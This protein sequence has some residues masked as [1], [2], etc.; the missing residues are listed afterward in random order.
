MENNNTNESCLNE[1]KDILPLGLS[2]DKHDK[3]S[4]KFAISD[5]DANHSNENGTFESV[6]EV[7]VYNLD[8]TSNVSEIAHIK[9]PA[10]YSEKT[11]TN[12]SSEQEKQSLHTDFTIIEGNRFGASV[13]ISSNAEHIV[14]ANY[15]A[16]HRY[17]G[18]YDYKRSMQN[19]IYVF[20]YN[21]S[22]QKYEHKNLLSKTDESNNLIWNY[23]TENGISSPVSSDV[24][25]SSELEVFNKI[26]PPKKLG[27][28]INQTGEVNFIN[29]LEMWEVG[30][31]PGGGYN[32]P[33]WMSHKY[34]SIIPFNCRICREFDLGFESNK[35]DMSLLHPN[36]QTTYGDDLI[37][38][39][40]IFVPGERW[41]G[42][43]AIKQTG[44]KR[45]PFIP[46][47]KISEDGT[48]ILYSTIGC[49]DT[50]N[51]GTGNLKSTD[52]IVPIVNLYGNDNK[53]FYA[54]PGNSF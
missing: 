49:K 41:D 39:N 13:D 36:L 32:I 34:A 17:K 6:G 29:N 52:D 42:D 3:Y 9:P 31:V 11:C 53:Y 28:E 20:E 37:F 26:N 18:K 1:K 14:V 25:R 4:P 19:S 43:E 16:Y 5:P 54:L 46:K 10:N 7:R 24:R 40:L 2:I 35:V 33:P 22:Q 30:N 50:Y 51:I 8:A 48:L 15:P 23:K 21:H 45:N 47:V 44:A 27:Y 12:I 38:Q